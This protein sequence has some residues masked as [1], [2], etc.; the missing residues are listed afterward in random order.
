MNLGQILE[1]ASYGDCEYIIHGQIQIMESE[2]CLIGGVLGEKDENG[3]NCDSQC[4]SGKFEIIDEKGYE[5]PIRTD[6]SCRTHVFNSR[7]LCLL[8]D[9][10]Q[11]IKA[12]LSRLR[13]DARNMDD[14]NVSMVTR[15]YRANIDAYYTGDTKHVWQGSDIS[16]FH[17][18][19]HYHRG[20]Q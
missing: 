3:F 16:E 19:G 8:E 13:I 14:Y 9:I 12:G 1:I 4:K 7:E 15:A 18:R 17:T 20:V 2:H 11:L 5:F 6:S 10:P